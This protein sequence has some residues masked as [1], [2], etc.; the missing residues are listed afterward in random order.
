[1]VAS[2]IVGIIFALGHHLFYANLDRQPAATTLEDYSILGMHVSVQQL[3]TAVG[4]AFAFLV[5]ACLMLSIS[6]A[7]FQIFVWSVGKKQG[8]QLAHLDVMTSA[9]NDLVSLASFGT[10]WRRPWLWLLAVVAWLMSLPSII[11]P[12]TLS[13]GIDFPP[14]TFINV[15]NV[16][17]SSLNLVAPL[18]GWGSTGPGEGQK[19]G[20]HYLYNGPS[21][22]VKRITSAVAAQGSILPVPALSV[23]STWDLDFDGP[24]LHCSP[25]DSDF[26]RA[27]LD[28]I[29]NYTFARYGST[30]GQSSPSGCAVGPGYM[31]W[32]PNWMR[33]NQSVEDLLPFL[34][35]NTN[36]SNDR[37]VA[38]KSDALNNDNSHGKPYSKMASIFLAI[39]PSLFKA[40]SSDICPEESSYQ[41]GLAE[42]NE[43]S[44]VLRCDMHKSTYHTAFSFVDGVQNVRIKDVIG[45]TETPMTTIGHVEAYFGSSDQ[46]DW[47]IWDDAILQPQTCPPETTD[48]DLETAWDGDRSTCFLDPVVLSTLS[49]QAIMHAF[50]DL[51]AGM[52]SQGNRLDFGTLVDSNTKLDSTVL[53]LAPEL[54]FL[55]AKRETSQQSAQQRAVTWNQQPFMG[56][57]N[58]AAAP[59]SALPFQEALEQ[60]F[61]NITISLMSAPDLQPNVSSAYFPNKTEVIS[62]TGENIYIYSA[63]KLWLAYGLAVGATAI[64]V[65]LGLAAMIAN[66]ASFTNRF[67]T[68][69]RLSRGAQLSYEINYTD[70]SGRDPL[71]TYAKKATVRFWPQSVSQIKDQNAYI[72]VNREIEEVDREGTTREMN[73]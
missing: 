25:V 33:P 46:D 34:I 48:S 10:W 42:Y 1:M 19:P 16:G 65:S 18:V 52:I 29:L 12:A 15:P 27:A 38:D 63:S 32:H 21:L 24:S 44:T 51:V 70:L 60:L 8:T 47:D 43:T 61:Q 3:N 14:P 37:V 17:F 58:A 30:E 23:N 45:I 40:G 26:R 36:P 41:A 28:N 7:Y 73:T 50:I 22:T 59:E 13:V 53:A 31:A 4:T 9:L 5:R 67:S 2:L 6:I 56:L 64:I 62:T 71:P 57:V 39:C 72:P 69:L 55:Q 11:T 54:A 66:E 20:I 68:I 35:Q 49:Y